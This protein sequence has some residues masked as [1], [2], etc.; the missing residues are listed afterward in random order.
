MLRRF[1]PDTLLDGLLRPLA[2][3]LPDAGVYVEFMAPDPRFFLFFA[4]LLPTLAYLF[5]RHRSVLVGVP[6][7]LLLLTVWILISFPIWLFSSGNGRYLMPIVMVIGPLLVAGIFYALKQGMKA[8]ALIM[9]LLVVQWGMVYNSDPFGVWTLIKWGEGRYFKID[10]PE[11]YRSRAHVFVTISGISYSLLAPQF[12]PESSWIHLDGE[13]VDT[14]KLMPFDARRRL[15]DPSEHPVL[16]VPVPARFK[17]TDELPSIQSLMAMNQ[18]VEPYGRKVK[19]VQD[20]IF[21][22]SWS[23][24]IFGRRDAPKEIAE[25]EKKGFWFCAMSIDDQRAGGQNRASVYQYEDIFAMIEKS[26]PDYFP[27]G[28][29][30]IGRLED[31]FEKHY[32]QSDTDVL[33]LDSGQVL[34]KYFR[35]LNPQLLGTVDEMRKGRFNFACNQIHGRESLPWLRH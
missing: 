32:S 31:G 7:R 23:L 24:S 11:P 29:S 19:S 25:A 1:I 3:A 15:L 28:Q 20:C 17:M 13:P 21:A 27:A 34:L 22:P 8:L 5:F 26:C 18:V 6:Q 30:R 16:L 10:I 2:M 4:F 9:L 14:S 12:N 35:Q 33:V